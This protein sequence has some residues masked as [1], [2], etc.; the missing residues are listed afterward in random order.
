MREIIT[1][2]IVASTL[3]MVSCGNDNNLSQQQQQ[4]AEEQATLSEELKSEL[5][6][7]S[8]IGIYSQGESVKSYQK[9]EYQI[10][11]SS[12]LDEY[13]VTNYNNTI[14]Y[15]FDISGD[16]TLDALLSVDITSSGIENLADT[17]LLMS[18]V[19]YSSDPTTVWLW[20]ESVN[21]GAIIATK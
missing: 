8:T 13:M 10:V 17:T 3:M 19:Q 14:F 15:K 21:I 18:V 12:T 6:E 1:Y 4:E 7:L 16:I 11:Y 9:G 5:L 2:I 20:D